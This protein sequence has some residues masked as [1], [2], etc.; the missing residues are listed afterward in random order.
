[1]SITLVVDLNAR[2][3]FVENR[4]NQISVLVYSRGKERS[5]GATHI[6]RTNIHCH[7]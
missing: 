6:G 7:F 4:T 1:M 2:G 5:N 3:C